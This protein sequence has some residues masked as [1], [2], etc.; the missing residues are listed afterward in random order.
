MVGHGN[1]GCITPGGFST[2][3]LEGYKED[4]QALLVR[5]EGWI[6]G[7]EE[8]VERGEE[9]R[10]GDEEEEGQGGRV[11]RGPRE[12]TKLEREEHEATHIPYREWCEHCVR[13]RGR[14]A[15]RKPEAGDNEVIRLDMDYCYLKRTTGKTQE[16]EESDADAGEEDLPILVSKVKPTGKIGATMVPRKGGNPYAVH[17]VTEE[18]KRTGKQE[19]KVRTDQEKAIR[20]LIE[21]ARVAGSE[22]Q[23]DHSAV[24][25]HV[26]DA[27]N[28][29]KQVKDMVRTISSSVTMRYGEVPGEHPMWG[30]LVKHAG[31]LLTRY[32]RG[33]DGRTA[34]QRWKGRKFNQ[35]TV[36]FGEAVWYKQTED[37]GGREPKWETGV[38]VGI[39]EDSSEARVLTKGWVHQDIQR[40]H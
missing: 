30:W 4:N 10:A 1:Y 22:C 13:G 7:E 25:R 16:G 12:P 34:H 36:P 37:L 39:E 9:Q 20:A 18:I 11:K 40:E 3:Q 31:D 24:G 19:V 17:W 5:P 14:A 2:A 23:L 32:K 8:E 35:W 27:E 33:E 21:G 15:P 29:V 38:W 6:M 28:A 26:G